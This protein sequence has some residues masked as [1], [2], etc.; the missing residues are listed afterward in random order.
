MTPNGKF[1]TGMNVLKKKGMK[2][3][4]ALKGKIGPGINLS[5]P[6]QLSLF[7]KLIIPI[8]T[9]GSDV[10][11]DE[12]QYN[13][14]VE[15][16]HTN[17]CRFI[18]KIPKH[19][20]K[21]AIYSELGRYPIDTFVQRQLIKYYNRVVNCKNPL[22]KEALIVNKNI[23]SNWYTKIESL[24]TK[25]EESCILNSPEICTDSKL[26]ILKCKLCNIF[27]S[28][29]KEDI[30]CDTKNKKGN[31]NK[32]RTYRVFKKDISFENYLIEI[33]NPQ[34]RETLTKFRLSNHKLE[35]EIVKNRKRPSR[36]E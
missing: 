14:A 17:F 35:I 23:R 19:T 21:M 31:G 26:S 1:K 22:L 2:A 3:L 18:L 9:Y 36:K 13:S 11:G 15:D 24:L 5:I 29:W 6:I 8:L 12:C 10:W 27:K 28:K 16:V 30:F 25:M 34:L 7:D 20:P 4:F 33:K 32:L